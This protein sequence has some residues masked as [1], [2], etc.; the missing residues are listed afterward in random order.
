MLGDPSGM[1]FKCIGC[2]LVMWRGTYYRLTFMSRTRS[3]FRSQCPP[4]RIGIDGEVIGD[5]RIWNLQ[6]KMLLQMYR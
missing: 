2:F 5:R 4:L 1:M 3:K 6:K